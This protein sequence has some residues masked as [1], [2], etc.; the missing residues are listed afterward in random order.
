MNDI[1]TGLG[2]IK[3]D[4]PSHRR[5]SITWWNFRYRRSVRHNYASPYHRRNKYLTGSRLSPKSSLSSEFVVTYRYPLKYTDPDGKAAGDEFD[6]IEDAATDFAYTYNDDSIRSNREYGS[7]IY[8]TENG[9]YTY[10]L[11]KKS[12]FSWNV[13]PSVSPN[14]KT[15]ETIHTHAQDSKW[16]NNDQ[17]SR[18]DIDLAD[19]RNIPGYVVL[20]SGV[21]QRYDPNHK[22][23]GIKDVSG[24]FPNMRTAG[25]GVNDPILK[26]SEDT[27]AHKEHN[28]YFSDQIIHH[29]PFY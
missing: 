20:P 11:P 10:S 24:G 29:R 15:L 14:G 7:S 28:K 16:E 9:K 23:D 2:K 19:E 26:F 25:N 18:Q 17:F 13:E 27:K 4:D 6:S 3:N 5:A 22:E 1:L 8:Q 21:L 12:F